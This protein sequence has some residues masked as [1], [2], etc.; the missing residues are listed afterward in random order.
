[1]PHLV[2]VMLVS[3]DDLDLLWALYIGSWICHMGHAC[4]Y[5]KVNDILLFSNRIV[6]QNNLN[7]EPDLHGLSAI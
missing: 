6:C 4:C 5:L 1:M 2:R 3:E 7:P